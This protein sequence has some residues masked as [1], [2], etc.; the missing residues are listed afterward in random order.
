MSTIVSSMRVRTLVLLVLVIAAIGVALGFG[1]RAQAEPGADPTPQV[2]EAGGWQRSVTSD[3]TS[4]AGDLC[5][6]AI[7]SE[8][9]FD[10]V[11]VRTP[12]TYADGSPRRQEYAGPLVVQV[13]NLATGASVQRDLSGRAVLVYDRDGSYDF[14]LSGPAAVG[15]RPGDSLPR[16]FY[17]LRGEHVIRFAVDGTRTITVDRGTEENLCRVLART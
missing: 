13:T 11:Y 12:A 15:F 7:R 10:A 8:V 3:F 1:S 6:F 4:P 9:L 2:L 17:V 5:R 14:R 16:G